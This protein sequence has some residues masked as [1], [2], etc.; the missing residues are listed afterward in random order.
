MKHSL[1]LII[2]LAFINF[3]T[4][5]TTFF[6]NPDDFFIMGESTTGGVVEETPGGDGCRYE[7]NC[8][9]WSA[10][11]PSGKQIR[12]C[13]NAGSCSDRY[14]SPEI[15]QNCTYISP[16]I[17]EDKELKNKTEELPFLPPEEEIA[18]K[19]KTLIYFIITLIILFII[20]YLKKNYFKKLIKK[21]SKSRNYMH[22]TILNLFSLPLTY[23]ARRKFQEVFLSPLLMFLN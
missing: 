2:L 5:E 23:S 20:L 4:T 12:G 19:N 22:N 10:C 16:E 3:A 8:I 18:D 13:I 7:W 17:E 15:E 6:D 21:Q 14:K 9:N 11:L 1:V